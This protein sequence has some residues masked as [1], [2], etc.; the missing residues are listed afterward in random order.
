MDGSANANSHVYSTSTERTRIDFSGKGNSSS[1][2]QYNYRADATQLT[3]RLGSTPV[4]IS[5]TNNL[6]EITPD[7]TE[8]GTFILSLEKSLTAPPRLLDA[9]WLRNAEFI[10][11]DITQEET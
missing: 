3:H 6:T 8:D 4:Q 11:Q 10:E 7:S 2:Y 1:S 5:T 9:Y